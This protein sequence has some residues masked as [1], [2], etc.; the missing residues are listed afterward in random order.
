MKNDLGP[1]GKAFWFVVVPVIVAILA[2]VYTISP[3]LGIGQDDNC[4]GSD[5]RMSA[6]ECREYQ[7]ILIDGY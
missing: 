3:V 6:Q 2:W 5:T 7:S 4:P 1:V